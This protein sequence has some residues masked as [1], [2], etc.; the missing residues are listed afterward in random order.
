MDP[1]SFGC[2]NWVSTVN[3]QEYFMLAHSSRYV[4]PVRA[5]YL[6]ANGLPYLFII[7][8]FALSFRAVDGPPLATPILTVKA[9][10]CLP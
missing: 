6:P 8:R 2:G 10:P 4:S 9:F 7:T 1:H 3:W 5:R